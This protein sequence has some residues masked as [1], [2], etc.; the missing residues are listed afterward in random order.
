M[1]SVEE[2][3]G[4]VAGLTSIV[5]QQADAQ[6]ATNAQIAQLTEA[7]L[8][9]GAAP[10]A[11]ATNQNSTSL[12]MPALQLPQF[13]YEHTTHDDVNEFLENFDVQTAHLQATTKLAL[14]Q[15]SCIGE[16][17][18][19]VLSMEKT[20][21]MDDT[22][23]QQKFDSFKNALQESF[24]EPPEVQRRRLASEFSSMKQRA[25]ESIERF[26]FRFKNNLHRLAKLG[27]PVDRNSPQ[28]IMSQF[29][30]K[31][32]TDIQKHLVLKAEEYKDLSEIIEAAKRIERSFSP[33]RSHSPSNAEPPLEP[34]HVLT[35]DPSSSSPRYRRRGLHCYRCNS[36]DHVQSNCPEKTPK[37]NSFGNFHRGKEVCRLWNNHQQSPCTLQDQSCRY[38]RQHKCN[39]C[40][41]SGCKEINHASTSPPVVNSCDAQSPQAT[42]PG[43]SPLAAMPTS[44]GNSQSAIPPLFM[45][46]T[47][48]NPSN[49]LSVNFNRTILS[50]QVTSAGKRLQLPLDSCCSVTLCNLEHAQFIH[51]S[52]PE[53]NYKK[54]DKH[55]PVQMANTSTSLKAVAVQEVPIMWLPDKETVHVALVVPNMSW[56]LLFGENHLAATQALSDHSNKTVTFRHPAMNFTISCNNE[57]ASNAPQAAVT[58]LLTGKPNTTAEHSS[59]TSQSDTPFTHLGSN[60]QDF[61]NLQL[62]DP[63]L[64]VIHKYLSAGSNKPALRDLSSRGRDATY[65]ALARDFYWRGMG[66]ATKRWAARC[67]E[68]C[69]HLYS[70]FQHQDKLSLNSERCAVSQHI[71]RTSLSKATHLGEL[72]T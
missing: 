10:A 27:E 2:L 38:G 7:L 35:T 16:W 12:R 31:T 60:K 72:I 54:L 55:I 69:K 49:K 13:R 1:T 29:T 14:L 19:S 20:K 17:P 58:C 26:A 21:F 25:T 24:A 59:T 71:V 70:V 48:S 40:S 3:Q 15:Q 8:A 5:K 51:S 6:K 46:P 22:T 50:C 23:T 9:H 64:K 67:L 45:M 68:A 18:N 32:K 4:I 11:P 56:P 37:N 33:G 65:H 41:K 52:R 42:H 66:K 61:I 47:L 43:P 62:Q 36:P 53:L 30:S 63:T 34:P 57:P 44:S 28:F 39:T